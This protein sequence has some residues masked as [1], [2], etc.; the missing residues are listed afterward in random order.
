MIDLRSDTVTQPSDDMR[1]AIAEA[2]VGDDVFHDDPT[3]LALEARVAEMLGKDDAMY[4]PS[5]TMANQVA[6]RVH[7]QPGDVVLAAEQAHVHIHEMGAPCALSGV[8]MQF[9][10][11][12][13][14]A[15]TADDVH[16]AIPTIPPSMPASLFQPV[17]LMCVENTHMAAG[18]TVWP[19]AALDAVCAAARVH[20]VATH[21]DGARIWNAAVAEGEPLAAMAAGFDTVSVCFSKGLGAPMG[22]ALVGSAA[23]ITRARRFKQM[24]GG[25]FRQAGMM[26]AGA[27]YALENNLDRLAEDH[28]NAAR[29]AAG[30]A[31]TSGVDV[32]LDT[33]DTNMVYFDVT[34]IDAGDLVERCT[35]EGLLMLLVGGRVR[36][37]TNL[38]IVRDD[39]DRA[40]SIISRALRD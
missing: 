29:L 4:V 14:G 17:T 8:T 24:F 1:R 40:L 37:V 34:A 27:L 36:A 26:A 23:A 35:A 20:G 7:T 33:V 15:F 28:I 32:D 10:P 3:V 16:G 6:L 19:V 31:E 12:E 39:I 5:G 22:S 13:R 38:H 25:G 2:P 11:T 30:L 21:M 9:L 18:G